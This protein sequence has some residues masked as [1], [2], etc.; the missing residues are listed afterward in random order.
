MVQEIQEQ[1]LPLVPTANPPGAPPTP[2]ANAPLSADLSQYAPDQANAPANTPPAQAPVQ[3]QDPA[4]T[5]TEQHWQKIANER[6]IALYQKDQEIER[7]RQQPQQPQQVQQPQSQQNGNPYAQ[8]DWANWMR[9]EISRG[10][11]AAAQLAADRS[12]QGVMGFAQQQATQQAEMNW[13]MQHPGVDI[14]A[15]KAFSKMR[16][17]SNID[18]AYM[19]MNMPNMLNSVQQQTTQQAFQNFNQPRQG[20]IP[21]RGNAG[22]AVDGQTSLSFEKMLQAYTQNPSIEN[23][24]HP[25]LKREFFKEL[26]YRSE[27][28][29]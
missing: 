23:T 27:N 13:A 11:E 5:Q 2:E 18:D 4:Q 12:L 10:Q 7:M 19:L 26:H 25:D 14:M 17:I 21:V 3:A 28:P 6:M 1:A 15:V 29:R 20:A 24:W 9:F 22:A 8:D 16:G